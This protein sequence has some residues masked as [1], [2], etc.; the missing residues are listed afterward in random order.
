M[1]FSIGGLKKWFDDTASAAGNGIAAGYHGVN[2]FDGGQGWTTQAPARAP[3]MPQQTQQ[4]HFGGTLPG[5]STMDFRINAFNQHA[6]GVPGVQPLVVTN[7]TPPPPMAPHPGDNRNLASKTWDQLNVFDNGRTGKNAHPTNDRSVFGQATHNGL[8]NT[9]GNLTYKPVANTGLTIFDLVKTWNDQLHGAPLQQQLKDANNLESHWHGSIPGFLTDQV[10]NG[11][12]ATYNLAFKAPILDTFGH[13]KQADEART[14]GLQEF[15]RTA[16]G[17]LTHPI[18]YGIANSQHASNQ[19]QEN[20]GLTPEA[21]GAQKYVGDPVTGAVTLYGLGKGAEAITPKGGVKITAKPGETVLPEP[22]QQ[23]QDQLPKGYKVDKTGSVFDSKGNELTTGQIQELTQPQ[24]LTDFEHASQ[25]GDHAT[26]ARISSEHPGD[27][28]VQFNETAPAAQ[29]P[30]VDP[31]TNKISMVDDVPAVTPEAHPG[32]FL[33]GK[34]P[35]SAAEAANQ[36]GFPSQTRTRGFIDTMMNDAKTAP[37]IKQKLADL[38]NT[39]QT[40]NTDALQM[41]AANFAREHPDEAMQM[42]RNGKDDVSIAVGHEHIKN[43]QDAGHIDTAIEVAQHMAKTGTD[44]GRG[45]QAFAAYARLAPEGI[46][47]FA[48]NEIAKYNEATGKKITLKAENAQKL[49]DMSK[50]IQKLPEGS[51]ERGYATAKLVAEVQK[52]M[53][54]TLAEK[55]GTLQTMAQL[56]NVKTNVRNIVGNGMF[57]GLENLSQVVATPVDMLLSAMR[58]SDRTTTLPNI[59]VQGK[60][61]VEG[62]KTG[63]KEAFDGINTGPSS[64]F[65]LNSVPVFRDKILGNL[66]KTMNATLRGGDRAAYQAAFD[67]TIHGLMKLNKTDKVTPDMLEQAHHTAL[68]RTFQD[69]NAVSDFFVGLKKSFNK[70]GIGIEGKRFGLGDIVLKYPKT[71]GNLLARGIDYSPAGF[72]KA[73]FEATKP[74]FGREFNQKAFVD[75]FSRAVTGSTVAFGMG[76]L[77]ADNG[78]ITAAPSQNKDLRNVQKTSGLGGYQI[79][80]S[81]FKRWV[82]SGFSKDA[83]KLRDGDT[84][85]SYDWAQPAAIPLSAG[86]ALGAHTPVKVGAAN[87]ASNLANSANTL[88][89]QPLLQG[90]Q[91]LFGGYG[92]MGDA[93]INTATSA[94]AS[95]VPTIISQLN[96]L[97]DNHS[98][99]TTDQN[100]VNS[101]VNQ[102]KAKIPG[103]AQ[104]LPAQYDVLGNPKERYQNGGNNPFNVMVN[105]AFIS[106]YKPTPAANEVLNLYQNTGET[107]QTPNTAPTSVRITGPDGNPQTVKLTGDQQSHYQQLTGQ[108][109]AQTI[110]QLAADPNYM[111]LPDSEKVKILSA[112]QTDINNAAKVKIMGDNPSDLSTGTA[113][114]LG[115]SNSGNVKLSAQSA[116]EKIAVQKFTDSSDKTKVIGAN[117]YYKDGQGKVQSMPKAEYDFNIANAK[118]NLNMDRAQASNDLG[119]WMKLAEQQYSALEKKKSLYDPGTQADKIDAITLQQENLMQKAQKY[120]EYGGFSKG[121]GSGNHGLPSIDVSI[122]SGLSNPVVSQSSYSAPKLI[123]KNKGSVRVAAR[124]RGSVR[125]NAPKKI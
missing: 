21:T 35:T 75:S 39:Y 54:A 48:Q 111:S 56:M 25:T 10:V 53:P 87:T 55:L 85:V 33:N 23:M 4:Y 115:G 65:D 108:L 20:V 12:Q 106:Q 110:N 62:G 14:T 51:K 101:A 27:H 100:P 94:P 80:A 59:K 13:T 40:R 124:K 93:A 113:S 120:Q 117:Y 45:V 112:K 90:V 63:V 91:R 89:E 69:S 68:Y 29:H 82:A 74:L 79:N 92:G 11:G 76:Y 24:F 15:N 123:L 70:V 78:I 99:I 49:V 18:Q 43:L 8:T 72:M 64:Q 116:N 47:R 46:L 84:L 98:R 58:G 3:A 9:A 28:R 107:K 34:Q 19:S 88:V 7:P 61:F 67:D 125:L 38:D 95:F 105:P 71:P 103:A 83:A 17:Q 97:F 32:T 31:A 30:V 41:K 22:L 2:P 42:A 1:G 52:Q 5:P 102:V 66:E 118:L 44:L 37:A 81:A 26:M 96:Q 16:P 73:T 36:S 50:E 104:T 60:G 119:T 6:A 121:S 57:G 122:P 109:T 114:I 86:A 77:L